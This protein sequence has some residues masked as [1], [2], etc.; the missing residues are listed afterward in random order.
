MESANLTMAPRSCGRDI[1]AMSLGLGPVG[2]A[3]FTWNHGIKHG[4]LQPLGVLAYAAP[5]ISVMLLA[6]A[7]I[8]EA[9][10]TLAITRL[11][12]TAGSLL[13]EPPPRRGQVA[14]QT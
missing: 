11:A 1:L 5:L 10:N 8:T 14:V 9:S 6:A 12:I 13:A 4:N 2:I 3:L 7:G